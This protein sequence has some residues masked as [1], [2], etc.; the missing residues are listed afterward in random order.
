MTPPPTETIA[1]T[2]PEDAVTPPPLSE[3]PAGTPA[4]DRSSFAHEAWARVSS[5]GPALQGLAISVLA[6][7][8]AVGVALL[9]VA[10]TG[11]SPEAA[12]S[13]MWAGAFGGRTQTTT[14]LARTVPLLLAA[15]GWIIAFS[16]RR[17]NIGLEG[18]I[19]AGGVGAAAVAISWDLPPAI[20]LPLA[21][22][23]GALAGALWIAVP[24][25][26]WARRGVNEVITTLMLNMVAVNVVSWLVRGP[27]QE[28]TGTFN[29]TE[30]LLGSAKWP[31]LLERTA[32]GWDLVFALVVVAALWFTLRRTTYGARLRFVA[33]NAEAARHL[34]VSTKAITTAALLGSGALA[35]LAGTSVM[36]AGE[37]RSMTDNFSAGYGFDGIVVALVARNNPIA[38]LPA[39]LL[40]AF[41]RQGGALLEARVGVS[42][43]VMEIAQGTVIALVAGAAM[44]E[45]RRRRIRVDDTSVAAPEPAVA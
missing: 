4:P 27:L 29:R 17:V 34:G 39:A 11:K 19:L 9:V 12:W 30:P 32:L 5:R 25:F 14:T 2:R 38:C 7:A 13:A 45:Q 23:A 21:V 26:L 44:F 20:H 16:A 8:A 42:A 10:A 35:G 36:L 18:Q 15:L 1:P 41:L 43:S 28:S 31:R 22:A 3:G 6:S 24:T 33:G 40:F 37:S